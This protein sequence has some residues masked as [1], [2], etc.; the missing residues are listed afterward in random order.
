MDKH[1]PQYLMDSVADHLTGKTQII[2]GNFNGRRIVVVEVLDE[3]LTTAQALSLIRVGFGKGAAVA[4]IDAVKVDDS[5][6][7]RIYVEDPRF[8]VLGFKEGPPLA[9]RIRRKFRG[10]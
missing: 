2:K 8:A 5:P 1:R 10:G 7:T 6:C 9:Q 4:G 3:C